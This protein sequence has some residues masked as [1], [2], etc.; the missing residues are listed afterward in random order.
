M[1]AKSFRKMVVLA[2]VVIVVSAGYARADKPALQE[3]LSKDVKIQL[4][5][6]T[7]VEALE[8]IGV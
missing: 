1:S 5:D 4:K 8:K 3:K 7:I 6:V 2:V